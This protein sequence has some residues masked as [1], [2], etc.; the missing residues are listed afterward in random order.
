MIPKDM[1]KLMSQLECKDFRPAVTTKV[2]V[3][4]N[5]GAFELDMME[6][7]GLERGGRPGEFRDPFS[8]VF[9]GPLKPML[10]P[11]TYLVELDKLGRVMMHLVPVQSHDRQ[12]AYYQAVWN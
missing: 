1:D 12:Y 8:L 6:A 10:N 11:G 4:T 3:Q 7:N 5:R 2:R 9:R